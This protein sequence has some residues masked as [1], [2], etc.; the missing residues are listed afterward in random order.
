MLVKKLNSNLTCWTLPILSWLFW[1]TTQDSQRNSNYIVLYIYLR[2]VFWQLAHIITEACVSH[3]TPSVGWRTRKAAGGIQ[4]K[5][6]R[7]ENQ[8]RHWEGDPISVSLKTQDPGVPVSQ[9]GKGVCQLKKRKP[10][11][12]SF[13]TLLVYS[14]MTGQWCSVRMSSY[15]LKQLI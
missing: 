11:C 4:C 2:D 15:L 7:P 13:S 3:S 10:I 8:R 1:Y 9:A 14:Q 6:D 5:T 12:L